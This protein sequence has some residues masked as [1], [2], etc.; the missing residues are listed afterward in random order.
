MLTNRGFLHRDYRTPRPRLPTPPKFRQTYL[1]PPRPLI[2][3]P[4]QSK[5]QTPSPKHSQ[6]YTEVVSVFDPKKPRNL[7]SRSYTHLPKRFQSYEPEIAPKSDRTPHPL[8]VKPIDAIF[9][10]LVSGYNYN[11]VK[12]HALGMGFLI[13]DNLCITAHSVVPDEQFARRCIVRFPDKI[14]ET[15]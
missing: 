8:A 7:A 15:H 5:Y 9:E 6:D 3:D 1:Q 4:Y 2:K 13:T 10:I 11:Q 14:Y 12:G